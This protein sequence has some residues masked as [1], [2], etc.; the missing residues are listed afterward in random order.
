MNSVSAK[1]LDV[2]AAKRRSEACQSHLESATLTEL[3]LRITTRASWLTLHAHNRPDGSEKG[4]A[5]LPILH[6][7]P[8]PHQLARAATTHIQRTRTLRRARPARV[9]PA[10]YPEYNQIWRSGLEER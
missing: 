10:R 9:R 2:N 5:I 3:S 1:Q 8:A 4:S 7:P 6:N